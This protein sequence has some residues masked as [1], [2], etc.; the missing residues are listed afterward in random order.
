MF[1][2]IFNLLEDILVAKLELLTAK[3]KEAEYQQGM[4]KYYLEAGKAIEDISNLYP[5]DYEDAAIIFEEWCKGVLSEHR[6]SPEALREY[7]RYT[8]K[9]ESWWRWRKEAK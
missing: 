9:D 6:P 7:A 1:K 8:A 5:V 3:V 4:N 2:R